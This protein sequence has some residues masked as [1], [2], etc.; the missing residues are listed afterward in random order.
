LA[1]IG[2][3]RGVVVLRKR[4]TPQP[5]TRCYREPENAPTGQPDAFLSQS[6]TVH[7]DPIPKAR[8]RFVKGRTYTDPRSVAAEGLVKATAR[9]GGVLKMAGPLRVR[10]SYF[11]RTKR[12]ADLDNL[13]KLTCDALNGLAW[14]D[15]SQI[16]EMHLLRAHDPLN[17]RTEIEIST[18]SNPSPVTWDDV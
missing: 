5:A 6:F 17:P 13:A 14:N 15:D 8:P 18:L 1:L 2:F 9:R 10:L 4:P 16:E 7:G 12:L 3:R 11:R